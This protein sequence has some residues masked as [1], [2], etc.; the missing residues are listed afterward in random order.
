[1]LIG[2]MAACSGRLF[3]PK[4]AKFFAKCQLHAQSVYSTN[5]GRAASDGTACI[6]KT[7]HETTLSKHLPW[8]LLGRGATG[9]QM[10]DEK[11]A[12]ISRFEMGALLAKDRRDKLALSSQVRWRCESGLWV[13]LISPTAVG[14]AQFLIP[15]ERSSAPGNSLGLG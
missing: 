13:N 3:L 5:T 2:M 9:D 8:D 15:V 11:S 10:T 4:F 1:M 6:G 14:Q 12:T 7:N